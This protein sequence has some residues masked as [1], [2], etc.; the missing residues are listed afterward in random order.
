VKKK[1]KKKKKAATEVKDFVHLGCGVAS[2][3]DQIPTFSK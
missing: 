3:G 2:V 1:K